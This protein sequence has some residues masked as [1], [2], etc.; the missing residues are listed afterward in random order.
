MRFLWRFM[1]WAWLPLFYGAGVAAAADLTSHAAEYRIELWR[2]AS[3]T[4]VQNV[5]GSAY[6]SLRRNCKGWVTEDRFLA[7]FTSTTGQVTDI[8]SRHDTWESLAGDKFIFSVI[9]DSVLIGHKNYQGFANIEVGEA[10]ISG[11]DEATLPLVRDT[12][13]PIQYM[14]AMLE[15]AKNGGKMF[16]APMFVGGGVEDSRYFVSA[17]IGKAKETA[18]IDFAPDV[19]AGDNLYGLLEAHYWPMRLAYFNPQSKEAVPEY[20]V[21]F[22][23]QENGIIHGYI[24][25]YGDFSVR[26]QL[27]DIEEL[28]AEEC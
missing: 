17:L 12:L 25:D 27:A 22:M 13:F 26:A 21:E 9:E 3:P 19:L 15:A 7:H 10:S 5:G 1:I 28:A 6:S 24:I 16:R 14:Q 8:Q 18:S 2:V 23:M 20:E 11:S 4:L